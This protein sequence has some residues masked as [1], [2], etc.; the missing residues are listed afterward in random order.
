MKKLLSVLLMA[1]IAVT[2]FAGGQQAE[3]E[4]E[5][6]EDVEFIIANGAE[7]ESLD[8]HLVSGVPEHRIY[9]SLFEGLVR[10]DPRTAEPLPAG[11]ESWEVSEDGTVYTFKLREDAV[12]SDG[13]PI[14]ADTYEKSWIRMVDPETGAPYAWFPSMFV[15]GAAEFNAGEGSAD[16]VGVEAIDEY[17]FQ[18][19]LVGPLPYAIGAMAHYSF[20]PVPLHAIEEYGEEWTL[21]ENFVGNG[22]YVLDRWQPQE[23]LSVVKSDTYWRDASGNANRVTFIPT[24][25]NN[26]MHNMFLN[27][28]VDWSTTVPTDQIQSA[29][30]RDD[31]HVAPYL[32]TYYYVYNTTREPLDDARVRQALAMSFDKQEIVEVITQAGQ[33][34]TD[35]M[36]PDMEGYPGIE[37]N[38]MDVEEAQQLLADAG[39][40][41]GEGF[42]E[43][44]I[45]YN[46]NEAHKKVAEYIQQQWLENLNIDVTLENQEWQTYLANRRAAEFDIARAGWIGD[47]RDP[48]T[49]LDMFVSGGAMNGGRFSNERYDELLAEA[50]RTPAGEER[51]NMMAEAE[52]ILVEQEQAVAPIYH[53]VSVNMIDTQTWDG[54]FENVMDQHPVSAVT[55][56]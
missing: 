49:F 31:Y 55:R 24:D 33:I 53:Y 23:D 56:N 51:Y 30:L 28:E 10:Y 43:L 15:E 4:G 13:T 6:M 36:V 3:G 40:P 27:G 44:S 25:D 8:P 32:G 11:A 1:L 37:G 39:Y 47:Y 7:P 12:W 21:P 2:A 41:N 38:E 50:A 34:P 26:T 19:E 9:K 48:N 20:S 14:T 42:P 46:T 5:M 29:R 52:S 22:A 54:W 45:L 16:D 17:T 18:V 35:A